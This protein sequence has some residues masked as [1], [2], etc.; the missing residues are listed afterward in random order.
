MT[1]V[2]RRLALGVVVVTLAPVV[3]LTLVVTVATVTGKA[4]PVA[5]MWQH[6]LD[7]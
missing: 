6:G 2:A 1:K 5:G 3:L 7:V 4:R